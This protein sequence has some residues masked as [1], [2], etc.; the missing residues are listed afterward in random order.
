MLPRPRQ[1]RSLLTTA[2]LAGLACAGLGACAAADAKPAPTAEA[3]IEVTV[4]EVQSETVALSTELAGR[5][6]AFVTAEVRPQVTGI[7]KSREFREGANVAAGQLLY[8]IEPSVYRATFEH[9]RAALTSAEAQVITTRV[10]AER[11]AELVGIN[12]VSKQEYDDAR[13]THLSSVAAVEQARAS[14][15]SARIN[16]DYTRVVAPIAGHIGRSSVTQG[17]LVTAGQPLA[18][19]TIAQLDP[20]YVDVTQSSV[21]LLRLKRLLSSGGAQPASTKVRLKLE[22]GSEYGPSGELQFTDVTVDASTGSVTL[23]ALFPNPDGLLL[24]GM[25]VRALL[26]E[27]LD[28]HGILAPQQAISRD[29]KGQPS[30]L[31]VDK[32]DKVQQRNLTT[33]RAIGDRWLVTGG[34]APGD[35]VIV[36]GNDK[37]KPGAQVKPVPRVPVTLAPAEPGRGG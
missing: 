33:S 14:L 24:P 30:A 28:P 32:D 7:I 1:L 2:R 27:A 10:R 5:T 22:D 8:V 34:L 4:V 20:I 21:Q 11:Y 35:R 19:A 13:A 9:A 16:L 36:E 15:Q 23:R 3:P 12:A 26:D 17:A 29:E 6:N 37:V 18:L 25:Y 31:V